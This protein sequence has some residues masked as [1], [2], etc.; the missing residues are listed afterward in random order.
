MGSGVRVVIVQ[1]GLTQSRQAGVWEAA[2]R[3]SKSVGV[4]PVKLQELLG[5]P[6]TKLHKDSELLGSP[7]KISRHT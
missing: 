2:L 6:A 5:G 3:R 4:H 7:A 1:P